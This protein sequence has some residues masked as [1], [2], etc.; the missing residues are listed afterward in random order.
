MTTVARRAFSL[1]LR[2]YL[3]AGLDLAGELGQSPKPTGD[4]PAPPLPYFILWPLPGGGLS[5]SAQM[6]E[7][8]ATLVYQVTVVGGRV[9]QI[10][11]VQDRVR[12]LFVGR[13]PNGSPVLVDTQIGGLTVLLVSSDAFGGVGDIASEIG[14][15][16]EVY[17]FAVTA[18]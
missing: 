4:D 17:A 7:A 2:D 6:I 10:E 11:E 13:N 9:D 16:G 8:D 12:D 1:G 5:G 3:R 15:G 18:L 14:S